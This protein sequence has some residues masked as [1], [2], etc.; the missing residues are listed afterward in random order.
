M[1][2]T[3]LRPSF[4][5]QYKII[6]LTPMRHSKFYDQEMHHSLP[7]SV[8]IFSPTSQK[9]DFNFEYQKRRV[10]NRRN[11]RFRGTNPSFCIYQSK[12]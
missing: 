6:S 4:P 12:N 3:F 9:K 11:E 8:N 1:K 5:E 10:K 2:T 7:Y